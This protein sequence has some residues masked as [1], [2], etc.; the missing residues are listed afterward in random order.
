MSAFMT[1]LKAL[2]EILQLIKA[3][4]KAADQAEADRKVKDDIKTIHQAFDAN[5][6]ELLRRLFNS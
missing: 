3:L 6:P 2:P 5:D 4:Q 1:L